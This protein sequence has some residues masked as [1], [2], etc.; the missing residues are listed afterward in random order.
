[1]LICFFVSSDTIS[2]D[3]AIGAVFQLNAFGQVVVRKVDPRRVE[4]DSI[5]LTFKDQY[6][7][8]SEMW[9]LKNS[10]VG[11]CVYVG[12]KLEYCSS[13]IRCQVHELWSSGDKVTSGLI[14]ESTKVLY[15]TIYNA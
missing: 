5:E 10:L 15:K 8:R 13:A 12:K 2:I 1:M 6:L 7:G 14:T 11:S 4:L 9:R 3:Q